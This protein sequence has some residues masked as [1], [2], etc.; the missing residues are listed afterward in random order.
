MKKKM[1]TTQSPAVTCG[2]GVTLLAYALALSSALV[3]Q[4]PTIRQVT[5]NPSHLLAGSATENNLKKFMQKYEK[6]KAT[7]EEYVHRLGIF[8]KN[9]IRAA[10]HQLL[11]PT[12]VHG[13]HTFL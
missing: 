3:P 11:D 12:A 8:A 10:E 7:R 4:N 9:M 6:S 13:D 5:D 2:F 1:A